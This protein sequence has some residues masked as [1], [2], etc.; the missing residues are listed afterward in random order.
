MMLSDE[1]LNLA[2][3]VAVSVLTRQSEEELLA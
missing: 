3:D 2:P 1:V